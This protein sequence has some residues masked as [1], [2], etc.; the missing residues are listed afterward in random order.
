MS[1]ANPDQEDCDGD[2]VGD[3]LE[4]NLI[5]GIDGHSDK[6][7]YL[8]GENNVVAGNL[9]ACLVSLPLA[10]PVRD[11]ASADWIVIGYLGLFG[12]VIGFLWYFQG[13]QSIGPSRAA[14]FIN[15]VPVNGVLLATLLCV[16]RRNPVHAVIYL[17]HALFALAMI[18]YLL[19]APLV[20]AWE[21]IIYA[22]AIMVL[23]MF[24]IMM[25]EIEALKEHLLPLH[26]CYGVAG[27]AA[28]RVFSGNILGRQASAFLW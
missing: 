15:F 17:V 27:T 9:I 11:S 10:L 14:V 4:G 22:G 21:V 25:L 6:A 24:I 2:G 18:F 12:T 26:V 3:E 5:A 13:I 23:F 8:S 20:A 7:V 1:I 16:T 19:G 28:R